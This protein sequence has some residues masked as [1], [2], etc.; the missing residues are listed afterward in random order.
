MNKAYDVLNNAEVGDLI[1]IC[2]E[3]KVPQYKRV[4]IRTAYAVLM[5]KC[6]VVIHGN[7]DYGP[8][9]TDAIIVRYLSNGAICKFWP[10]ERHFDK[11]MSFKNMC[12]LDD[13]VPIL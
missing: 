6:G 1:R 8:E 4:E 9:V 3:I 7:P 12:H 13:F 11:R 2:Y 5:K 10:K